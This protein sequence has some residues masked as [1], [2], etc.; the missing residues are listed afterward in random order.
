MRK[1]GVGVYFLIA[2]I[3]FILLLN[4]GNF[5]KVSAFDFLTPFYEGLV[6]IGIVSNV[7]ININSPLNTTYHFKLGKNYTIY[8]NVTSNF[9]LSMWWYSLNGG[10][11]IIFTPNTTFNATANSNELIVF[12]NDTGGN[13]FNKSVVFFVNVSNS[14]PIIGY[15]SNEILVCENS[16]LPD[17]T[18]DSFFNV[19]DVDEDVLTAYITPQ[20]PFY[21]TI[22]DYFNSTLT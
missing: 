3:S 20:N 1:K 15:I 4:F 12:A 17:F 16:F 14:N 10:T 8:L 18:S 21:V 5:L 2:V 7:R 13:I 22:F 19:S 9:N 6:D 11:N